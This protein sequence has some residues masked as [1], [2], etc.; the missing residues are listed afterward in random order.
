MKKI[1]ELCFWIS[2]GTLCNNEPSQVKYIKWKNPSEYKGRPP[3]KS[4]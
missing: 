1:M 4:V 3:D 2:V